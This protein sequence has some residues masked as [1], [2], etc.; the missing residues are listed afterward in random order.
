M[1]VGIGVAE[2]IVD[3]QVAIMPSIHY[4]VS[5]LQVSKTLSTGFALFKNGRSCLKAQPKTFVQ[6]ESSPITWLGI[7]SL[8]HALGQTAQAD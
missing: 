5:C 7:S 6:A 4:S 2:Q 3:T 8:S 1:R